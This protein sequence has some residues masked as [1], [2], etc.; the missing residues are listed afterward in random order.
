MLLLPEFGRNQSFKI[1]DQDDSIG[2]VTRLLKDAG[3]AP[4]ERRLAEGLMSLGNYKAAIKAMVRSVWLTGLADDGCYLNTKQCR[5]RLQAIL[6]KD[7]QLIVN[8][9]SLAHAR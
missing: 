8:C 6:Q 2:T 7:L 9:I 4:L 3:R 1:L 5:T